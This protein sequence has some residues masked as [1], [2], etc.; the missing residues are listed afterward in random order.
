MIRAGFLAD[1][2]LVANLVFLIGVLASLQAA[3]TL[4]GIAGIVLTIGMAVDAN[5]LIFDR[6]REEMRAGRMVKSAVEHGYSI[7]GA[8]SAILDANITTGITAV[9]LL[10]FGSGPIKG[11]ATTLI[12]GIFTSLFAAIFI[13]RLLI[14]NRLEKKKSMTFWTAPTKNILADPKFNFVGPRKMFYIISL[15]II[16]FGVFSIYSKGFT[17]G[18]DFD[19]GY[20]FVVKFDQVVENETVKSALDGAFVTAVSYTHLTLPTTSRV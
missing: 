12:I 10:L 20:N 16:G 1:V 11:F 2:A 19:G 18:V 7:K 13:T 9:I 3:L 5:V 6:I 8:L 14:Y 17:T 15:A 4:P